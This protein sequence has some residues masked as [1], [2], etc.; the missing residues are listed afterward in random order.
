MKCIRRE[1]CDFDGVMT[2]NIIQ[3]TPELE[4]LRVPLIPCVN[5]QNSNSIDVCCRDPNYKDPWP[6]MNGN[7]KKKNTS[8]PG[9]QQGINPRV[10]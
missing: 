4:M 3:S 8:N 1:Y 6:N 5:R 2:N 7:S 10:G 9:Y